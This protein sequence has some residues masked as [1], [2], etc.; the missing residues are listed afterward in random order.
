MAQKPNADAFLEQLNLT[1]GPKELLA[2]FFF[3]AVDA[4]ARRG[5]FLEFGSFADLLR[6]N[7][8]HSAS[9]MPLTTTFR[10]HPGGV[11][12]ETGFVILGRNREG[13]VVATQAVR[14]FDWHNTNFKA[15]ATSL[16]FFYED[17]QRDSRDG[18][19][20]MVT[21]PDAETIR[22]CVAVGGGIWYRPDFRRLRLGEIIPRVGRAYALTLW[23]YDVLI[24]TI[25]QQN[26]GK[27]FDKRLGFRDVAP[28]SIIMRH[29]A[30][31]PGGDLHLALARM[32]PMQLID[33]LFWFL[34]EFDVEVDARVD[35]RRA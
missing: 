19:V 23:D 18:E 24:A 30:T 4:A 34:S 22:G 6:T 11:T 17:P 29:S 35:Q 13:E 33:D 32:T 10:E 3:K 5:V 9:W 15:E 27:A 8:S 14:I 1:Y 12:E 28:D 25:T 7:E 20:C 21:T 16:R 26:V 2:A 31:V